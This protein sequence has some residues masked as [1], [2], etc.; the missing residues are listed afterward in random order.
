MR[1]SESGAETT[2]SLEDEWL[3]GWD[4]TPG[5]VSVWATADGRAHVW[6][7]ISETGQLVREEARFQPWL[8]LDRLDDL[9]H[10][11]N[12]LVPE[13]TPGGQVWYRELDGPGELRF[14]VSA[15]DLRLLRSA[16]L[17][18]AARRV[19][20]RLEQLRDLGKEHVLVL[21]PEEQY[22]VATGRTYF[23][24][25]S[26]DHLR[27]LQFDLETGG[28]DP[29]RD[30]I[31]MIAVRGPEGA[32][33]ILEASGSGDAAEAELIRRLV[34]C[35]QRNDPDVIENHNLH[36]FDLPFLDRRARTLGVPLTL[37]RIE[38]AG[39]QQRAA[40]RG[41]VSVSD[42]DRRVRF[43]APGRELIDTMDAVLR[44][45]F[46]ARDLPGHGL[47]AV[48]RHFGIAGA[49]RELI[50]GDRIHEVYREDPARVRRYAASDVEEVAALARLLG[51]RSR[52]RR[53]CSVATSGRRRR[54]ATGVI[55]PAGAPTCAGMA[56]P[57]HVPRRH[58]PTGRGAAPR[59][60]GVAHRVRRPMWRASIHP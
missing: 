35:V 36:G 58:A 51:R 20:R 13:G 3:W 31:F 15:G 60:S 48:A 25:L 40:R 8:L 21:P 26:F 27:R 4:P 55:D 17:H 10:L 46:S 6:R 42:A 9:R 47:K 28:L 56:L 1:H 30:R 23:R 16:V 5:I 19:G 29:S 52:S 50:P 38:R 59:A 34:A 2:G 32:T 39:L 43:A 33:E 57:A 44:H 45:D 24:D 22:L 12:A 54:P 7:R 14:L 37:G 11:G 53:W 18:G 49:D 41:L